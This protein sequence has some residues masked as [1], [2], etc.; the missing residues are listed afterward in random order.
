MTKLYKL[1][2]NIELQH[3][4]SRILDIPEVENPLE[5]TEELSLTQEN[6]NEIVS[7]LL[8]VEQEDELMQRAVEEQIKLLTARKARLEKRKENIRQAILNAFIQLKIDRLET[9]IGSIK[10]SST[11]GAVIIDDIEKLQCYYMEQPPKIDKARLNK[12]LK[13]GDPIDG[14]HIEY[15]PI[16]RISR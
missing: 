11:N 8:I 6:F 7:S 12:D 5:L 4:L 16:L 1:H 2:E 14:A 9:P 10:V 15:R 3:R 13:S